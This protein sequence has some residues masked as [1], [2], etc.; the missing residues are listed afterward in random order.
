MTNYCQENAG[1]NGTINAAGLTTMYVYYVSKAKLM[2][3]DS[4]TPAGRSVPE[5]L[6]INVNIRWCNDLMSKTMDHEKRYCIIGP[7]TT[8]EM[9]HLNIFTTAG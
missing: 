3:N 2:D 7:P 9:D 6:R 8:V 1:K 5:M 4:I